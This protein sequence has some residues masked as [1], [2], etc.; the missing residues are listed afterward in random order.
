M[1]HSDLQIFTVQ[2]KRCHLMCWGAVTNFPCKLSL[3]FSPPW[4][5]GAPNAP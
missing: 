2:Q 4:G 5:A 3:F 1:N